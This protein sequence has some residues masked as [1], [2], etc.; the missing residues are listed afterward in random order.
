MGFNIE[1][2]VLV[3]Y[4]SEKGVTDVVIPDG[5]TESG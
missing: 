3:K 1:N 4:T 5:V 2:G